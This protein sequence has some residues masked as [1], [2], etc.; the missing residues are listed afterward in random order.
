MLSTEGRDVLPILLRVYTDWVGM[1][2]HQCTPDGK[3]PFPSNS[4]IISHT[5]TQLDYPVR[6]VP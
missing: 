1:L 4:G 6:S 3:L 2:E 5:L